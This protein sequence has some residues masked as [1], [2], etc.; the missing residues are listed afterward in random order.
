MEAIGSN[1]CKGLLGFHNFSG[2]DLGGKFVGISKKTWADAYMRL[3]EDD[4]AVDCFKKIGEGPIAEE[5]ID[6]KLSLKFKALSVS[7][8]PY[9]GRQVVQLYQQS[10]GNSSVKELGR[11]DASSYLVGLPASYQACKLHHHACILHHHA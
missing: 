11:G 8:V 3:E 2:A 5:L 1:K 10:D 4:P 9:T 7:S 6:G